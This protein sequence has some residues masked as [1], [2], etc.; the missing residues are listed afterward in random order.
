MYNL[1][2][3]QKQSLINM[4]A[5]VWIDSNSIEDYFLDKDSFQKYFDSLKEKIE[6]NIKLQKK[7][8]NFKGVIS[9]WKVDLNKVRENKE[10]SILEYYNKPDILRQKWLEY[11]I[12]YGTSKKN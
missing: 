5:I 9:L 1:T 8:K 2:V 7:I 11:H 12:K 10:K 3:K 4:W 6:K